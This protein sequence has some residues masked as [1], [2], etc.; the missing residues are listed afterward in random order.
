M[1]VATA[2]SNRRHDD[3][4]MD[5]FLS[6]LK[7]EGAIQ[8]GFKESRAEE[9]KH[10]W[11]Y[12]E[13][14]A[15]ALKREGICYKYDITLPHEKFFD[16]ITELRGVLHPNSPCVVGYGHLAEGD[17]HLNVIT[18]QLDKEIQ[19][20]VE[21]F[22]YPWIQNLRGSISSEHGLGIQRRDEIVYSK[23][24]KGVEVMRKVKLTFDPKGILNP[25]KVL[26][27]WMDSELAQRTLSKL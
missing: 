17:I 23:S 2:G 3:E 4:K 22:L 5:A 26:P 1:I 13:R 24:P 25:Y 18:P 20:K 11:S 27:S 7:K 15:V 21:G 14:I 10:L 16:V 9:M 12:R 6:Q 8:N 19:E